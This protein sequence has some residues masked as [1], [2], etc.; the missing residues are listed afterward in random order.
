MNYA[1]FNVLEKLLLLQTTNQTTQN[2]LH[3]ANKKNAQ[4]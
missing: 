4:E 1:E 2:V 3:M